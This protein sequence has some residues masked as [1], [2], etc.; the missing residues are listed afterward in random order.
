MLVQRTGSREGAPGTWWRLSWAFCVRRSAFGVARILTSMRWV[1]IALMFLLSACGLMS[2]EADGVWSLVEAEVA[3]E[4]IR[5]V[6][7]APVTL[8]VER[9]AVSGVA[10]CNEYVM[11]ADIVGGRFALFGSGD[12][13]DQAC[14]QAVMEVEAG[15]WDALRATSIYRLDGDILELEGEGILL[16]FDRFG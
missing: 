15:Y 3:G 9:G 8:L 7:G 4:T 13:A 5:P 14:G 10:G 11:E 2:R 16:R 1:L 6:A 12:I